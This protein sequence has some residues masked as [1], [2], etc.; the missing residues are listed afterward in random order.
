MGME[1]GIVRNECENHV[2]ETDVYDVNIYISLI[3]L[4]TYTRGTK[5]GEDAIWRHCAKI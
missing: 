5:V 2:Y 3:E 4:D 1:G